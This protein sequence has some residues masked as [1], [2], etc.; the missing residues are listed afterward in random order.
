MTE[1]NTKYKLVVIERD[2]LGN[3]LKKV[4]IPVKSNNPKSLIGKMTAKPEKDFRR[5][6][7]SLIRD[8]QRKH[9]IVQKKD[10]MNITR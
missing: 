1:Q 2:R 7:E 9:N 6:Y 3:I 5:S 8:N 4:E 10:K